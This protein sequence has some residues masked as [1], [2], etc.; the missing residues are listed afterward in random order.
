MTPR[1]RASSRPSTP[2]EY[3]STTTA[4][5]GPSLRSHFFNILPKHALFK[6]KL[7]I[8]QISNVPLLGGDFAVRWR[9]RNVQSPGGSQGGLLSKM[10]ANS[11]AS[12]MTLKGKT[13]DCFP[14]GED[15]PS[16]QSAYPRTPNDT[17]SRGIQDPG[18]WPDFPSPS[19]TKSS[20][21]SLSVTSP[22]GTTPA[23]P[24]IHSD[25]RGITA[26]TELSDHTATWDHHLTLIVRMDVDRETLDL[27]A[28]ELKLTVLQVSSPIALSSG[29]K[30]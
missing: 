23:T 21:S 22:N 13:R 12:S 11:P 16:I 10:K 17:A 29:V 7:H 30:A 25:S 3:S 1:P 14:D 20:S 26:W 8:L 28:C 19:G 27:H 24:G 18:N 5:S 9:F 15:S 6:V 2:T 4:L